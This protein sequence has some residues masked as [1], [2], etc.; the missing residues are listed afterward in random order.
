MKKILFSLALTA[1][2]A[3]ALVSCKPEPIVNPYAVEPAVKVI[4]SDV[5]F[6]AEAASGDIVVEAK[7]AIV[8]E[9]KSDWCTVS[10]N[11]NKV[12]ASVTDNMNLEGRS[13]P[14]VI[15]GQ[16]DSTVVCAQQRGILVSFV[17]EQLVFEMNGGSDIIKGESSFP[18]TVETDSDWIKVEPTL[19]G[20]MVS[21]PF[22]NSGD[23]RI[24]HVYIKLGDMV[25]TYTINQKFDRDFSGDYSIFFYT[26][27]TK[28]ASKTFDVTITR[29]KTDSKSYSLEG[30]PNAT[31]IPMTYD[32]VNGR[33]IIE[34]GTYLGQYNASEY[35]YACVYYTNLEETSNYY[36]VST[37]NPNYYIYFN[38]E[39]DENGKYKM[40]LYN[41]AP[42]FNVERR[43]QGFYV[44]TFTTPPTEP[45]ATANKKTTIWMVR[46]PVITQK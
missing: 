24:G 20:F 12:T 17:D 38:F 8:A 41:S 26:N 13:T 4:G 34:N 25:T 1:I 23:A 7:G 37:G 36:N 19:G 11:G 10:V 42:M 22:N 2:G 33:L 45:L 3:I 16:K 30:I 6:D 31:P 21:V 43:S 46:N 15:R 18:V 40:T 39:M 5:L 27:A 14:I 28:S 44:Y 32:D 29:S 9:C 35:L